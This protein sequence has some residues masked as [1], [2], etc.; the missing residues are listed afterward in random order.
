[1]ALYVSAL[2]VPALS[3]AN[4]GALGAPLCAA[5]MAI[6][7][8]EPDSSVFA[9][10]ASSGVRAHWCERY[11]EWGTTTRSGP[12][13]ETYASGSIR[14]RGTYVDSRL[15]GPV[16]SFHESGELFLRGFLQAG[17]WTG[18][19]EIY[20]ENGAPWFQATMK[21]GQLDGP[22]ATFFPD[23]GLESETRFQAGREDGK[24]RSFFAAAAGGRLKSEA[25]IEADMFI[26][27]HRV[28]DREGGLV[29]TIDW[30][31]AP[32][33]WRSAQT[34]QEGLPAAPASSGRSEPV[35]AGFGP[36]IESGPAL[37]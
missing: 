32:I 23:G 30:N 3:G 36:V 12:Y 9:E 21:D 24:A 37:P 26:G 6:S 27:E 11:D 13:W 28:L 29:R 5:G 20:H 14:V 22:V 16:V 10:S 33:D 1:V 31:A 19:F 18:A 8:G 15:E 17:Q 2:L 4:E 34:R 35:A 25:Q 7:S